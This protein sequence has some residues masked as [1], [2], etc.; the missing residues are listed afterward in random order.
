MKKINLKN[1]NYLLNEAKD[2]CKK[3]IGNKK[4]IHM[5]IK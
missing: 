3:T 5:I 1:L 2:C 4:I